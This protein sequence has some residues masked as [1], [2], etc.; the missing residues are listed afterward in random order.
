MRLSN[1]DR[2]ALYATPVAPA[3]NRP[4]ALGRTLNERTLGMFAENAQFSAKN[5]TFAPGGLRNNMLNG[6]AHSLV[7]KSKFLHAEA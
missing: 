1:L 4:S 3:R 6:I 2:H 7:G 5:V